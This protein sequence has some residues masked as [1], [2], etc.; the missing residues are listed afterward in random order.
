MGN[1]TQQIAQKVISIVEPV[2]EELGLDLVDVEYV[3][4]RG[5][6]VLR[7][8]IDKPG[9]VTVDDCADVSN[10]IGDLLDVKGVISGAYILEVSSPG[11]NR[12]LRKEKDFVWATGKKIR[13]RTKVPIHGRRNFTGLLEGYREGMIAIRVDRD[14]FELALSDL[15]KA[16]LLYS[17]D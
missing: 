16:N 9:G 4:E 15:E 11:L 1:T 13:V 2:I 10:E 12:P 6:W 3:T 7:V 5:R 17:F 14:T 8:Y